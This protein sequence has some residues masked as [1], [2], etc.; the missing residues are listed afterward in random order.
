M[1]I[2]IL[3]I[4]LFMSFNM[5]SQVYI[6]GKKV[7]ESG[8]SDISIVNGDVY[9]DGKSI[10]ELTEEVNEPEPVKEKVDPNLYQTK[11][12]DAYNK[13]YNTK[14]KKI[15]EE[16][17]ENWK[18]A[19]IWVISC[20]GVVVMFV[21]LK[22]VFAEIN[23]R[24]QKKRSQKIYSGETQHIPKETKPKIPAPKWSSPLHHDMDL[25]EVS[26]PIKNRQTRL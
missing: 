21:T 19:F 22:F 8:A 25:P 4:V 14:G 13:W 15:M 18:T 10:D 16:K 12:V 7:A 17:R 24:I 23:Q 20:L 5:H 2:I 9:I 6:N 3:A 26:S 11:N 1:K